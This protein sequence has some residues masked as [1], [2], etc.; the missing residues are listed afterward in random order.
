MVYLRICISVLLAVEWVLYWTAVVSPTIFLEPS[1]EV[2]KGSYMWTRSG[3]LHAA[4]VS[5][6]QEENWEKLTEA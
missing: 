1:C 3:V 5:A 4:L 2:L 6:E